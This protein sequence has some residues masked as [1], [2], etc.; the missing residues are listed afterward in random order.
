MLQLIDEKEAVEEIDNLTLVEKAEIED[1]LEDEAFSRLVESKPK[2]IPDLGLTDEIFVDLAAEEKAIEQ[3]DID[4]N[5]K[6][7]IE[8]KLEGNLLGEVPALDERVEIVDD[9]EPPTF[10][11]IHEVKEAL[12]TFVDESLKMKDLNF[13]GDVQDQLKQDLAENVLKEVI[14]AHESFEEDEDEALKNKTDEVLTKLSEAHSYVTDLETVGIGNH[15]E[16]IETHLEF[17]ALEDIAEA[18]EDVK[19]VEKSDTQSLVQEINQEKF[20]IVAEDEEF[21]KEPHNEINEAVIDDAVDILDPGLNPGIKENTPENDAK[22]IDDLIETEL[23][24]DKTAG[25]LSDAEKQAIQV[26]LEEKVASEIMHMDFQKNKVELKRPIGEN[27]ADYDEAFSEDSEHVIVKRQTSG[28]KPEDWDQLKSR[29]GERHDSVI[30]DNDYQKATFNPDREHYINMNKIEML[31]EDAQDYVADEIAKIE[32]Y[33]K[34]KGIEFQLP[35]DDDEHQLDHLQKLK[36]LLQ[37]TNAS[38]KDNKIIDFTQS[39]AN[40]VAYDKDMYKSVLEAK[41]KEINRLE[42]IKTNLQE[43]IDPLTNNVQNEKAIKKIDNK[44]ISKALDVSGKILANPVANAD[45]VDIA[46]EIQELNHDMKQELSAVQESNLSPQ[47]KLTIS[48]KVE[49]VI[50]NEAAETVNDLTNKDGEEISQ[51]SDTIIKIKEGLENYLEDIDIKRAEIAEDPLMENVE[52]IEEE[53][54]LQSESKTKVLKDL[55]S[56]SGLKTGE[57][58]VYI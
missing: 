17:D 23:I 27:N 46:E 51:F 25:N 34:A 9:P 20:E 48:E 55:E 52:K 41:A 57:G 1:K 7:E 13:S 30:F 47:L 28:L 6:I 58:T 26:N 31:E 49:D 22:L 5:K 32:S 53:E 45:E 4:A 8:E 14:D 42:G 39:D 37:E 19:D 16:A 54:L 2:T 40:M 10:D 50:A 43:N 11:H 12:D 29:V 44:V 36:S 3:L 18:V 24:L 56:I 33:L 21:V 35:E 15:H 38:I